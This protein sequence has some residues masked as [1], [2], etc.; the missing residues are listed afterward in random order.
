MKID[1]DKVTTCYDTPILGMRSYQQCF[2]SD[3]LEYMKSLPDNHIDMI[4]CDILYGTGRNFAD[5][6]DL[7]PVKSI[8][9]E[10]YTPRIKEMHRI[11][12]DTGSIYLQMDTII[13]HWI[14][15]ILDDIFGYGNFRNE[16]IWYYPGRE[17]ISKNKFQSKH[18]VIFFYGKSEK[19]KLNPIRKEWDREKRI[20]AMRR[21]IHKDENGKEWFWETRGQSHGVD[22]YKKSL[23]EYIDKGG[24]LNDVWDD[25]QFLRGNHPERVAYD[26]QKPKEL[27]KRI[28]LAS[29][30]ENDLVADFY[31]G[32]GTTAEV[33]KELNRNFIGCDISPKAVR[34][35]NERL[36]ATLF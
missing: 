18:D 11:L 29:S 28:I 8:I 36:S 16:I 7:K 30:N 14:R 15:C 9:E 6:Q 1:T 17:R 13:S 33:C 20:K 3:N 5:Y 34:I 31:V 10:H 12:K 4:Y 21:K 23:D 25:I 32:S 27:L 19:S 24:A 35:T 22:A 26:T 2:L